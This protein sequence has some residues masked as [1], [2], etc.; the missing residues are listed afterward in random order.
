[1]QQKINKKAYALLGLTF[2]LG[3]GVTAIL[4]VQFY[5]AVIRFG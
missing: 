3:L 4:L 2:V 5:A 1:M